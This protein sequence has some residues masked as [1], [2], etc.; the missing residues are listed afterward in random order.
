MSR[1]RELL[2]LFVANKTDAVSNHWKAPGAVTRPTEPIRAHSC[3]SWA[4]RPSLRSLRSFA[5]KR[6]SIRGNSRDS[7]LNI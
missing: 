5:A 4:V 2:C 6:F 1:F 3:Y 7:R